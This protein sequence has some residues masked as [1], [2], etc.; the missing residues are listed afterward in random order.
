MT[1]ASKQSDPIAA[2][3]P[4]WSDG[5][6]KQS[7]VDFVARVTTIGGPDF[8]PVPTGLRSST[9]TAH[10]GVSSRYRYSCTSRSTA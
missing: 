6:A 8:V 10:F 5:S 2:A 9:T 1:T 3:L 7:I 4:S